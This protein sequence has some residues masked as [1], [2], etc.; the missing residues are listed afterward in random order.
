MSEVP[1]AVPDVVSW[2]ELSAL[3][4]RFLFAAAFPRQ[5]GHSERSLL[6]GLEGSFR[7][8]ESKSF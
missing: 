3:A 1:Q 2:L 8:Q 4:F 6:A 7:K 5:E